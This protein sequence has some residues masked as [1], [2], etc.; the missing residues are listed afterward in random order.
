MTLEPQIL[1]EFNSNFINF[2]DVFNTNRDSKNLRFLI[3][4][5]QLNYKSFEKQE[6]NFDNQVKG[7]R[8]S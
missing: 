1:K 6:M 3:R 7:E 2:R 8:G 4:K 5:E